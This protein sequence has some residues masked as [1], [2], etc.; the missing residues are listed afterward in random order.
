MKTLRRQYSANNK[1]FPNRR[2]QLTITYDYY[3]KYLGS[4]CVDSRFPSLAIESELKLLFERIL[5]G[6]GAENHLCPTV[7]DE[8]TLC[9]T[10]PSVLSCK[11]V[12]YL[13]SELINL[14]FN[15]MV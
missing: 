11:I 5:E 2:N 1:L 9:S 3:W 10:F 15:H 6:C 8:I 14:Q 7:I 13:Q 12:D 4:I